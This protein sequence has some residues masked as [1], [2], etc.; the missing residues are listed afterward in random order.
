MSGVN[1]D[2]RYSL[3]LYVNGASEASLRAIDTLHRLCADLGDSNVEIEIIDV[4]EHPALVV[5]D[6]V[7]AAPTLI[8]AAPPPVRRLIGDLSDIERV[9]VALDFHTVDAADGES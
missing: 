6:R 7:L 2:V 1:G 9:R 3:R 8:K 5:R 4:N